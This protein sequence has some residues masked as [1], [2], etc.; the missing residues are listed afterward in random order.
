MV[1]RIFDTLKIRP[2]FL[3]IPL[4]MFAA[5][6]IVARVL[7]PFRS[8]SSAMAERMNLDM[9]LDHEDAT[10]DFGFNPKPFLLSHDDVSIGKK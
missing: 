1:E 3:S 10:R 4:W 8:W 7:P 9:G 5:G 2:R 6:V